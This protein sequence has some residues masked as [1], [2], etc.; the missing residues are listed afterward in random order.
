GAIGVFG[1][2]IAEHLFEELAEL[3]GAVEAQAA[4]Q[5]RTLLA[6]E[7]AYFVLVLAGPGHRR[8]LWPGLDED[9]APRH[10][11]QFIAHMHL[12]CPFPGKIENVPSSARLRSTTTVAMTAA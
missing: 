6:Q 5:Q 9:P 12:G 4:D 10:V 11:L 2:V 8:G 1:Q 3:L 7:F